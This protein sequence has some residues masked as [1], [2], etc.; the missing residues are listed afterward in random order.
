VIVDSPPVDFHCGDVLA[1]LPTLPE[2]SV[3]LVIGSPPYPEKGQRYKGAAKKMPT[4]AWVD[5]MLQVTAE[6]VRICRGMV[7]WVANGAVRRGRYLPACEG[8][9]WEWYKR[10]GWSD[11]SCIWH[12]N[13]P[14]NRRDWFG[15]DWEFV[16][17]FKKPGAKVHFDW[18]AIAEPPKFKTGGRFR[19]RSANGERRLGN[20]YPK[21]DLAH[22]RDV[23]RVTVGGGHM[24]SMLAHDGEAPYPEKLVE[25]FIKVLTRPGDCVCD[26]FLGTGTTAVVAARLQRR[27][28]G[29]DLRVSQ[30]EL[31]RRRLQQ[32]GPNARAD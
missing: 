28:L 26:P 30:V 8:L 10:G 22:P 23:V 21:S 25:R 1:I 11:R 12:K 27:F 6:S 20:E 2:N 29:I 16:L 13:A 24:G 4:D 7:L 15:N 31:A 17:A 19:Q 5:W 32:G 9:V 14:P 18:R 3:D